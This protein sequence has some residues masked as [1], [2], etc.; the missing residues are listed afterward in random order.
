LAKSSCG[1]SPLWL[2]HKIAKKKN[3]D[4]VMMS[5]GVFLRKDPINPSLFPKECTHDMQKKDPK[6]LILVPTSLIQIPYLDCTI[7]DQCSTF[8][9]FFNQKFRWTI[10]EGGEFSLGLTGIRSCAIQQ[11]NPA[12][13]S[14]WV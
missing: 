2:Q 7:A 10:F 11:A 3:T 12:K 6:Q 5:V 13:I 9:L 1:P 4:L 8:L 14:S